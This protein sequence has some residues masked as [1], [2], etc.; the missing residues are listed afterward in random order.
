MLF[1][2]NHHILKKHCFEFGSDWQQEWN[3][4]N[5]YKK[6]KYGVGTITISLAAIGFLA[7]SWSI[8]A[9]KTYL[10]ISY[11]KFFFL[12]KGIVRKIAQSQ[13]KMSSNNVDN[14]GNKYATL[15]NT[16]FSSNFDKLRSIWLIL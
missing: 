13:E 5:N 4:Y 2:D 3:D 16:N 15:N 7:G 6:E 11:D 12:N 10:I 9:T 14:E 8:N 1:Q